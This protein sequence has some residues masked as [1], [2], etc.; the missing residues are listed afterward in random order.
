[1]TADNT[2]EKHETFAEPPA[3]TVAVAEQAVEAGETL[4]VGSFTVTAAEPI[5]PGRKLA[6][7]DMM[8]DPV[9]GIVYGRQYWTRLPRWFLWTEPMWMFLQQL[10]SSGLKNRS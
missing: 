7:R 6:L 1:V 5:P 3:D 9:T 4:T 8:Q 10:C 2:E